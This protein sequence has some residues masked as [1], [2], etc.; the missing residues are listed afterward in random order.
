MPDDNKINNKKLALVNGVIHTAKGEASELV[1]EAGRISWLGSTSELY[2]NPDAN[3]NININFNSNINS[4]DI[5]IIDLEGR[6]VLPGLCDAHAGLLKWALDEEG[7]S[8]DDLRDLDYELLAKLF[9]VY[10]QKAA[11]MGITE[12]W[13][14]DMSVFNN[15]FQDMW[16]FFISQVATSEYMPLR[17]RSYISI[18]SYD[19]LIDFINLNFS[20]Y[21]GIPFCHTGPVKILCD[22]VAPE[23]INKLIYT[24]HLAGLQIAAQADSGAALNMCLDA[25]EQ[26]VKARAMNTRHLIIHAKAADLDQLKRM[27]D[28]RLGAVIEPE[29]AVHSDAGCRWRGM[30]RSGITFCAGS[31]AGLNSYEDNKRVNVNPLLG[32]YYAVNRREAELNLANAK[33]AHNP[34][35]CLSI[36]EA[37]ETY[38][39]SAAW[40]GNAEK[41][42]GEIALWRDAD[43]VVLNQD[44]FKTEPD[45][46]KDLSV[47]MTVCGGRIIEQE[48]FNN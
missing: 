29:M 28:L 32:L 16:N 40:N 33:D 7:V 42:R 15:K 39:Y 12:L 44:P 6:T 36:A 34:I 37:I 4:E 10:S 45:K 35:E 20:F 5:E 24:A 23:I 48:D 13:T 30:L 26:A 2:F 46:L 47:Y 31:G 9:K 41:R 38:T 18:S 14:D 22:G 3:S 19:E 43:L 17:L 8:P 25:F 21:D 1:I 27:R 11:R